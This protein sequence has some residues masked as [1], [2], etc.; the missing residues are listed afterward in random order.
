MVKCPGESLSS[1][2][3]LPLHPR[4]EPNIPEAQP[5]QAAV[6]DQ[7]FFEGSAATQA[8]APDA[9]PLYPQAVA[10]A[11]AAEPSNANSLPCPSLPDEQH[12]AFLRLL[13]LKE[14]QVDIAVKELR[15]LKQQTNYQWNA[16]NAH[17]PARSACPI[18]FSSSPPSCVAWPSP[19]LPLP[20]ITIGPSQDSLVPV[21]NYYSS[22]SSSSSCW[23][24]ASRCSASSSSACSASSFVGC[25]YS[26]CFPEAAC[27][28]SCPCSPGCRGCSSAGRAA[29]SGESV[30]EASVSSAPCSPRLASCSSSPPPSPTALPSEGSQAAPRQYHAALYLPS[31][32]SWEVA[33][34]WTSLP[35][36]LCCKYQALWKATKNAALEAT[37]F[38]YAIPAFDRNGQRNNQW[39]R[40][41]LVYKPKATSLPPAA[42]SLPPL[43]PLS[44][45]A[46]ISPQSSA[47]AG[48]TWK[49]VELVRLLKDPIN[50]DIIFACTLPPH[51]ASG[52]LFFV[53]DLE[54]GDRDHPGC[55][56]G[57]AELLGRADGSYYTLPPECSRIT[58]RDGVVAE[59][60]R[61]SNIGISVRFPASLE[62]GGEWFGATCHFLQE[63]SGQWLDR[64]FEA[65]ADGAVILLDARAVTFVVKAQTGNRWLKGLGDSDFRISF[66]GAYVL[67]PDGT[68]M[69]CSINATGAAA[70]AAPLLAPSHDDSSTSG[71][72]NTLLPHDIWKSPTCG[73]RTSHPEVFSIH[74]PPVTAASSP[75]PP[76]FE[77]ETR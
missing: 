66:P 39:E 7:R 23:C 40:C 59:G 24:P 75:P 49:Q 46:C 52:C 71:T 69:E 47:A 77:L 11:A 22:C 54:S 26:S 65:S 60:D 58:L 76:P 17:P 53:K 56:C 12:A 70:P 62:V 61:V 57:P 6:D 15:Q 1:A 51:E 5:A 32:G 38:L 4:Q 16:S 3:G 9:E 29:C 2:D 25:R 8:A 64:A 31:A 63:W 21:S 44:P 14:Q 20:S 41:A 72:H 55:L 19:C 36:Q 30:V 68:L 43:S 35:Q 33:D 48:S 28:S 42:S 50:Y 34:E 27:S 73:N 74:T 37:V 10:A 18:S 67:F 13:T 45:S